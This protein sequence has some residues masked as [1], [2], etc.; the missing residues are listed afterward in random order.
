[1]KSPLFGIE[2]RRQN[3]NSNPRASLA[4]MRGGRRGWG[5]QARGGAN[6]VE[7]ANGRRERSHQ[8]HLRESGALPSGGQ[9]AKL[10]RKANIMAKSKGVVRRRLGARRVDVVPRLAVGE[11]ESSI[12][13]V[14]SVVFGSQRLEGAARAPCSMAAI[15]RHRA[16]S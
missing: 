14:I 3:V 8:R 1:M 5:G 15:S 11:A 12:A 13:G 9:C 16:M 10:S 2:T 7:A 6:V 4:C